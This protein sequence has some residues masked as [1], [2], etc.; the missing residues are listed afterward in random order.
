MKGQWLGAYSGSG[1]GSVM[2]NI[3]DVEKHYEGIVYLAPAAE[4]IIYSA[5]EF[6]TKNRRP[7][8][9]VNAKVFPINPFTGNAVQVDDL[10][11]H[12]GAEY[13]HASR[14]KMSIAVKGATM[15]LKAKTDIGTNYSASLQRA[16]VSN[17]SKTRARNLSW[18]GYKN[19]ISKRSNA[20]RL[21]RG[22]EKPWS[23]CTAFHRRGRF[24]LSEFI[25]K[26]VRQL[27]QR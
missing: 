17:K 22:Q 6:S 2:V 4:P 14:A 27:H 24:R 7:R 18:R 21:Y 25:Q 1:S 26:D 3:D 10:R 5:V 9:S 13:K 20:N 11:E 12:L 19:Y 23:L 8:Q 16:K 15:H